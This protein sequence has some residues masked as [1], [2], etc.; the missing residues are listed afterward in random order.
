[1]LTCPTDKMS[2]RV[3][4]SLLNAAR[5]TVFSTRNRAEYEELGIQL[6]RG[7]SSP[8]LQALRRLWEGRRAQSELFDTKRM[9]AEVERL[10]VMMWNV[11]HFGSAPSQLLL[12]RG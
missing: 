9:V 2:G 7:R 6:G 5:L 12:H 3:G 8:D 1:M 4:A 11:L 10:M